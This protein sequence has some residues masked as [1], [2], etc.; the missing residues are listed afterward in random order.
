MPTI[1]FQAKAYKIKDWL[2]VQLPKAASTKLPSRGMGMVTTKINGKSFTL[3][4]EPDG[5][6]SHWF[7]AVPGMGLEAG[8]VVSLEVTP[9]NDWPEPDVPADLQKAI[10]GSP[11]ASK[12]WP[13]FTVK[14]KWE[15]VRWV[16][17]TKQAQTR[18]RRV[19]VAISKMESGMRRPCCFNSASCTEP[20][21]SNNWILAKPKQ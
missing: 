10:K 5:N 17:S 1:K 20:Y 3:P 12:S 6:G 13:G 8:K 14:A 18:Q 2:V 11:K 4:L 16:R 7:R 19:R 21:V 15:W 9:T